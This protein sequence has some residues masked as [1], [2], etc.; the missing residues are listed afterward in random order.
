M[1][2]TYDIN[3]QYS[4]K[5]KYNNT[6]RGIFENI[7]YALFAYVVVKTNG[8]TGIKNWNSNQLNFS[9]LATVL[10]VSYCCTNQRSRTASRRIVRVAFKFV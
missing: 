1:S 5:I 2:C 8:P 3:I 10:E 4:Y 7:N 9:R 6:V